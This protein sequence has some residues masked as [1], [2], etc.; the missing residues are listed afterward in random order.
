MKYRDDYIQLHQAD[1]FGGM[2]LAKFADIILPLLKFHGAQSVLDY[3][4]GKGQS[5]EKNDK[6]R[7]FKEKEHVILYDPG[8]PELSKKPPGTFAAVL[9]IDVIEHIPEEEIAETLSDV[10]RY[11]NKV[12]IATF[13]PRGS[14]KKLPSTGQDVH[15]TQR[16]REF[17]ERKFS[18][19]N[20]T[21]SHPVPF[22]LFMNP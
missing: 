12:V 20:A 1:V 4:S 11:A 15:V 19:A 22:Y 9:C 21:R 5:W 3:G 6:L 10:F 7:E 18:E 17:W 13:C 8:V 16:D 14:K 2:T